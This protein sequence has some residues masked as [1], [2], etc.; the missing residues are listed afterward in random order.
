MSDFG[1]PIR[2]TGCWYDP[3]QKTAKNIISVLVSVLVISIEVISLRPAPVVG[4]AGWSPLLL[5][6]VEAPAKE[7]ISF[8][9]GLSIGAPLAIVVVKVARLSPPHL[10]WVVSLVPVVGVAG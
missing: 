10:L 8:S 3:F 4:V 7:S 5:W 1:K 6:L 2:K 9:C